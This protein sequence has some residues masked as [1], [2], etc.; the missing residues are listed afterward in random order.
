M[1]LMLSCDPRA[2]SSIQQDLS[3][4]EQR[5]LRLDE[6]L[7]RQMNS[8]EK[9]VNLWEDVELDMNQ[10]LSRITDT[11][12]RLQSPLPD[13]FDDLERELQNCKVKILLF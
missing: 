7:S 8:L 5:W 3:A 6:R 13:N 9:T 11:R 2:R 4:L 1:S 12:S 10:I